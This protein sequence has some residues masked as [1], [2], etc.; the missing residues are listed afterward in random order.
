MDVLLATLFVCDFCSFLH[1]LTSCV[2]FDKS[3]NLRKYLELSHRSWLKDE[4]K[5]LQHSAWYPIKSLLLINTCSLGNVTSIVA[6]PCGIIARD[7]F[8]LMC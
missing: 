8:L 5:S 1:Q 2:I 6:V 3:L 4:R 7:I